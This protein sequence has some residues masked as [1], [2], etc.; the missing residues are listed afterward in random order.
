MRSAILPIDLCEAILSP[1]TMN[2]HPHELLSAFALG[3]LD[4]EEVR[5]IQAHL[6]DC[7]DCR[8]D[9]D[10][11]SAMIA[12]LPFSSEA[13]QPPAYV[14]RRLFALLD[15]SEGPSVQATPL[16][17]AQPSR[18]SRGFMIG[19]LVVVTLFCVGFAFSMFRMQNELAHR[20]R[21]VQLMSNAVSYHLEVK[22][23]LA[24]ATLYMQ[25]GQ[26]HTLLI[27]RVLNPLPPGHSY[28]LWLAKANILLPVMT[29][30]EEDG[31]MMADIEV[32]APLNTYDAMMITVEPETGSSQPSSQTVME[33]DLTAFR[34]P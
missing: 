2:N 24:N 31:L 23:P 26:T 16:R 20:N 17:E 33:T 22:P 4:A 14:K 34:T 1:F 32:P 6:D 5:Q 13:R 12:L 18:W 3:V 7:I 9:A 27:V 21:Q 15:V 19:A 25:P 29:L 11:W 30:N 28:Q 10:S 8:N